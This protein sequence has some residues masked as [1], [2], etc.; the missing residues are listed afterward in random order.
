[1]SKYRTIMQLMEQVEAPLTGAG[2]VVSDA[3][4]GTEDAV[5]FHHPAQANLSAYVFS[6]GQRAG[7]LG[8]SLEFPEPDG[9]PLYPVPTNADNLALAVVVQMLLE[10]FE[11]PVLA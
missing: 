7:C 6:Y 9:A 4:R 8:I 5:G 11:V 10:H 2:V 1:M 3:W